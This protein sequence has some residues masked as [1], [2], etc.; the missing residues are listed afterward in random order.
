MLRERLR[1]T[2]SHARAGG[3]LLLLATLSLLGPWR[4]AH[5]QP[6]L[7]AALKGA[8]LLDSI[9]AIVGRRIVTLSQ[10]RTEA[11]L[12]LALHASVEAAQGPL[13]QGLLSSTLDYV[14]NEDLVEEEAS[15][16]QVFPISPDEIDQAERALAGRFP[17]PA[18][19]ER[20]LA[21]FQIRHERVRT[22]LRRGLRSARYLANRLLLQSQPSEAEV[23]E[24][25]SHAPRGGR[26]LATAYLQRQ[27]Y[28]SLVAALVQ[29]LRARSNVRILAD[30]GDTAPS[31]AGAPSP[32]RTLGS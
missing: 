30:F 22:I 15:R 3:A 11:R 23:S 12:A 20:F 32:P 2:R 5:A 1:I 19:Y 24:F 18:E 8:E 9:A 25:L 26:S 6:P 13:S 16:L 17:S 27:R 29:E 21:R 7:E 28:Q 14:V 31:A 4:E 10:L